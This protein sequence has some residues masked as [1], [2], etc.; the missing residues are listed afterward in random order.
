MISAEKMVELF[1]GL[2]DDKRISTEAKGYMLVLHLGGHHNYNK[3]LTGV[4]KELQRAGYLEIHRVS[5]DKPQTY[6]EYLRSPHWQEVRKEALK[7]AN[8]RCQVCNADKPLDVHH[9]TYERLGSELD[10]DVIALCRDCH[11]LFH[12]GGKAA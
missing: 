7:R 2:A 4:F 9:R 10:A 5:L 6:A 12:V 3:D 1:K 11:N 8:Y